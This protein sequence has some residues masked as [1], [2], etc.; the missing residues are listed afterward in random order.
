MDTAL[1]ALYFETTGR[2]DCWWTR[3]PRG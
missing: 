3:G 1:I 2:C